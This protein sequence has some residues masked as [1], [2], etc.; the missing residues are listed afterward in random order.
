MRVRRAHRVWHE[1]A[2]PATWKDRFK[3]VAKD[4]QNVLW[5]IDAGPKLV[6]FALGHLWSIGNVFDVN[7]FVVDPDEWRKGHGSDA[8]LAL[9]RYLFDYLDLRLVTTELARGQRGRA[10]D[11]DETRVHGVRARSRCRLS[12]TA[13]TSMSSS[14]A[15]R[16][17]PG[18][19]AGAPSASNP[20]L[21]RG[22]DALMLGPKLVGR[23]GVALVP[24][25]L[26]YFKLHGP[27]ML[28][29]EVGRFWG[30][31]FGEVTDE[32]AE[33]RYTEFVDSETSVNWTIAYL[34]E[35]VGFTGI[36]DIDWVRRD[37]ESGSS[38]GATISSAEGSR[39]KRSGSEPIS[40]GANCGCIE[41]TTGSR[42][43]PRIAPPNEKA[44]YKQMGLFRH[45][46]FRSGEWY[47][48]WLGEAYPHLP[49]PALNC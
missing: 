27:W 20:P 24:M 45:S 49:R 44:G 42:R 32:S 37:G 38:S 29:P 23:S 46:F 12:R 39:V 18:R 34:D 36:F 41:C 43:Q 5:S 8:A 17:R 13:R 25:T 30:P 4:K 11:S 33:K 3:E 9:H 28:Q 1:P 15:W 47:D 26:E 22:R 14:C 6:G 16:R 21:A 40:H 19:S 31:R 10:Q 35:P 48:E 7:H 2:M